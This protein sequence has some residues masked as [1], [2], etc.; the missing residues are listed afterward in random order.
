MRSSG[1]EDSLA[2]VLIAESMDSCMVSSKVIST[3]LS[4]SVVVSV[5]E[6]SMLFANLNMVMLLGCGLIAI[7]NG[8]ETLSRI[9]RGG[10]Y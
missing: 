4:T 7:P 8:K 1:V 5:T 10:V 3:R 9:T 2:M 6:V